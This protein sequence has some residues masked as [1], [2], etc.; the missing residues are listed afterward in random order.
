MKLIIT[1]NYD[2]MSSVAAKEFA[3]LVKIKPNCILGLATGSTPEG[4]YSKLIQLYSK[5]S[6]DFS[7]VSSFNLD[8][9]RG[10]DGR[11]PQSYRY[12]MDTKLFDHINID[13][14]NT[15]V[16]NGMAPDI[17]AECEM[18]DR[19]IDN[20]GGIDLQLLGIGGNGHIGFNEPSD[21][22][23]L[24][25]HLTKL[26]SDTITANSRF[27]NSIEEVPTEAVTMGLGGIMKAK[28]I[29]LLASGEKKA[30]IIQKLV[31]GKISTRVPASILQVHRNV[32]VIVDKA[33]ASLINSLNEEFVEKIR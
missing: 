13:K 22:L 31:S 1:D 14:K 30:P 3:E 15:H 6:I 19:S 5:N 18:Y 12:F 17:N 8:E 28:R 25:T 7:R 11:H 4:V 16:P 24:G 33:A 9:Y 21:S 27:F 29:L 23:N 10:L 20:A 32:L 26:M 2:E